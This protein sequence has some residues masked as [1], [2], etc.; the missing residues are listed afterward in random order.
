MKQ[1]MIAALA[2]ASV[3]LAAPAACAVSFRQV[4]TFEDGTRM[5]WTEGPESPNPPI[6]IAS[7]GPLGDGDNYLQN[8]SAGGS[9]AGSAMTMMNLEQWTGDYLA[10]N[11]DAVSFDAANLGDSDFPVSIAFEGGSSFNRY[12]ATE[13]IV[14]PPDGQWRRVSFRLSQENM[15][16]IGGSA[17]LNDVLG[18]VERFRIVWPRSDNPW[19]GERVATTLGVDNIAAESDPA[20]LHL[21]LQTDEGEY[22]VGQTVTWSILA[23]AESENN[24]GVSLL[25]VDL[26]DDQ[27][28]SLSPAA[29]LGPGYE[30]FDATGPG[31]P[32]DGSPGL[33]DVHAAQITRV[34][35][36]AGDGAEQVFATGSYVVTTPGP[37]TLTA[38]LRAGNYWPTAVDNAVPFELVDQSM[39]SA[40]FEVTYV[41]GDADTDGDVDDDDLS[42]LLAHWGADVTGEAD[43]GWGSGEFSAAPP[44]D[45]DDLSLLLAHWNESSGSA[46]IPEPVT[47]ALLLAIGPLLRTRG[48]ESPSGR[49]C[50]RT[51]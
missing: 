4:D 14:L 37:H 15:T 33:Q 21:K 3:G 18:N 42:L 17:G 25:G 16:Q 50:H 29:D 32:A 1:V 27:G 48:W 19:H 31:T 39:A 41:P 8:V 49:G 10:A 24:R 7:S 11:V 45:D 23:W 44:V 34:L 43:G 35:D 26:D 28:E 51:S 9:G 12:V 40:V 13:P 46:T 6:N 30:D 47:I 20:T 2:A 36:V 38:S 5:D 22:H